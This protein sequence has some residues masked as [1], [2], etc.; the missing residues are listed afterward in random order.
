MDISKDHQQ[1]VIDFFQVSDANI[2]IAL[3]GY[4]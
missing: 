1:M 4:Y 2:K 3:G